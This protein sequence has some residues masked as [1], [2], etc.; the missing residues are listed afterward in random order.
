MKK[1]VSLIA[2]FI[3]CAVL[4]QYRIAYSGI[5]EGQP[6]L[7]I[8]TWDASGYYMYLPAIFIYHD[9]TKLT[10]LGDVDKKYSVTGGN[11]WQAEKQP[12]GN[13]VYKYL[14]GVAIMELPFFLTGHFIAL[15]SN[16]PAD[17]YSAPYEYAIAFGAL[18]YCMLAIFLLRKILL[19]Y[20]TDHVAAIAIPM[21]CL[22]T[23]FIEY[24]AIESGQSHAWIFPLYVLVLYATMKWHD[25]PRIGW[26]AL[27]GYIIG[28]AMISRPTEAI[29]LFIPLMWGTQNKEAAKEKWQLVKQ[30]RSHIVSAAT[31]GLIGI[32]PQLIYWKIASGS[33]IYDVGSKWDFLNPHFRVLFGWE[34]GWFIYTP[35]T[36]FFIIG[37]FFIKKF[38][39]RRSVLWFCLLNIY[40]IIAWSD[41]R[42]GGSY[43]TRA[44]MQS[45][46]IFALPFAAF[47]ECVETSRWRFVF[48][49]LCIYL[50]V[51][52]LFQIKQ[53]QAT[54]LHYNDMNRQYYG[55]IYLNAHP[56][57]IDMSLLDTDE[58]LKNE[59]SYH[60]AILAHSDT[61]VRIHFD[62]GASANIIDADLNNSGDTWMKIETTIQ[63]MNGVW[64]RYLNGA[65]K[66]G[67]SVK[68]MRIRMY[69][70]IST[71]TTINNYAFYMH[72]PAYFAHSHFRLYMDGG[73]GFDGVMR[74]LMITELNK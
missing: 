62:A 21:V 15:H 9:A 42:Y 60:S 72:I 70:G 67:D 27:I 39:F 30:H 74:K 8:T 73:N 56:S 64:D 35:V 7:N 28:L 53:Y 34:K 38:P 65:V 6:R 69:N 12:N 25:R 58:R 40:I 16:Y 50:L 66:T 36:L 24:V 68:H 3:T 29:M 49:A 41:W 33:F 19:R 20:F 22:A 4:L 23:N 63:P 31:F 57:P 44:L 45:Y 54:I 11:G 46:G 52:N 59:Q 61:N 2:C 26:A 32:L 14:G 51:V 18:L 1:I 5:A 48:Y 17:G 47:T 13:Y 55:S 43:S 71:D 37:M 10:W